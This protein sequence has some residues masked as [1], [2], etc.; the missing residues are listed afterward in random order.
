MVCLLGILLP[1]VLKNLSDYNRNWKI[2]KK[3]FIKNYF[4][5]TQFSPADIVANQTDS[6]SH[7]SEE[8]NSIEKVVSEIKPIG[9]EV[10]GNFQTIFIFHEQIN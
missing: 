9:K 6:L 4:E 2:L 7:I 8:S 10:E 1:E 5:L 3:I